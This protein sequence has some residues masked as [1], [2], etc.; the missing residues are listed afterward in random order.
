MVVIQIKKS[1]TDTFLHETT[2]ATSN[3]ELI[4]ELVSAEASRM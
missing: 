2:C 4:R 1:D 3:D